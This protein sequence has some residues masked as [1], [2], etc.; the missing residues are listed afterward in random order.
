MATVST[1]PVMELSGLRDR[2]YL[3]S[4]QASKRYSCLFSDV[5]TGTTS[6]DRSVLPSFHWKRRGTGIAVRFLQH[7]RLTGEQLEA[8]GEYRLEQYILAGMYDGHAAS[9]LGLTTDPALQQSFG[10]T[11]HLV[12][13]DDEDHLLCYVSFEVAHL[14]A[15]YYIQ[16][17][18]SY[19][20]H[21]W[22]VDPHRRY[23]PV[24]IDYGHE[25]YATHPGLA[26]LPVANVREMTRLVR[27]QAIRG[28]AATVATTEV[29][30]A[31]AKMLR[32]HRYRVE[33][34]IGC[35][36]PDVRRLL[37]RLNIPMAYAPLAVDRLGQHPASL[38]ATIWSPDAA[39]PGKFWPIALSSRDVSADG[40][41]FDALDRALEADLGHILEACQQALVQS[42][43][44]TPRY[45]YALESESA[46]ALLHPGG[47]SRLPHWWVPYFDQSGQTSTPGEDDS[48]LH[49]PGSPVVVAD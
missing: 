20:V 27:N 30:V 9:E 44:V 41:Y 48:L 7:G 14:P 3:L 6:C 11:L 32:A 2:Q 49:T 8:I 12:I 35:A 22:M 31:T 46:D 47:S 43:Q 28:P 45:S 25:L 10:S 29:I 5:P 15:P 24:E 36:S 26:L 42:R 34:I 21:P 4:K 1:A 18:D 33:A 17:P 19:P 37:H 16:A 40:C 23:F 38:D 13:G 39:R